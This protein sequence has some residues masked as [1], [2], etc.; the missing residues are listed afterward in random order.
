M[1]SHQS[2]QLSRLDGAEWEHADVSGVKMLLQPSQAEPMELA[3]V[4]ISEVQR[5]F[6]DVPLVSMPQHSTESS[7]VPDSVQLSGMQPAQEGRMEPLLKD[8]AKHPIPCPL[9][10]LPCIEFSVPELEVKQDP[11]PT[12]WTMERVPDQKERQWELEGTGYQGPGEDPQGD[13]DFCQIG[14]G[15]EIESRT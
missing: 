5:P 12:Q 8:P 4:T 1:S 13:A 10:V 2:P 9:S 14:T 3:P 6:I 15:T 11:E 7:A